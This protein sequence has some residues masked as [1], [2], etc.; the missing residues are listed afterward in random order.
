V[1]ELEAWVDKDATSDRSPP[2]AKH[3]VLGRLI[4]A[5]LKETVVAPVFFRGQFGAGAVFQLGYRRINSSKT[6]RWIRM[7]PDPTRKTS[8][9]PIASILSL[10]V[11]SG[12][13]S[14]HQPVTS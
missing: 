1:A 6:R 2:V 9:L 7:N 4:S 8:T 12:K 10:C 3:I 13:N 11:A 5:E 14:Q